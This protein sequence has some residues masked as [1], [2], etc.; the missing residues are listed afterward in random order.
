MKTW[1]VMACAYAVLLGGCRKAEEAGEITCR[2]ESTETLGVASEKGICLGVSGYWSSTMLR[3]GSGP[4]FAAEVGEFDYEPGYE[5]VVQADKY[6]VIVPRDIY[7]YDGPYER[8]ELKRVLSKVKRGTPDIAWIYPCYDLWPGV[9]SEWIV[10]QR[11]V[12]HVIRS[13]EELERLSVPGESEFKTDFE[14]Y[15][16]LLTAGASSS[17]IAKIDKT[18]TYKG[19]GRYLFKVDVVRNLT[20]V[21]PLWTVA[22][23]VPAIP[24]DAQVELQVACK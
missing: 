13:Q 8:Y 3:A 9:P 16:V 23:L 21:A 17:G 19:S 4:W 18:L 14:R 5:Y 15:S 7:C 20:T 22:V 1:V 11:D 2:F 24:E 12:L 6:R 10:P